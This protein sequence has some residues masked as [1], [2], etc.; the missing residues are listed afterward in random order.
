VGNFDFGPV[1]ILSSSSPSRRRLVA[2]QSLEFYSHRP[3]IM[4]RSISNVI[5]RFL[6]IGCPGRPFATG[7]PRVHDPLPADDAAWD[8]GVSLD[9]QVVFSALTSN[10]GSGTHFGYTTFPGKYPYEQIPVAMPECS[11]AGPSSRPRLQAGRGSESAWWRRNSAG[12]N[13]PSDDR[14]LRKRGSSRLWSNSYGLQVLPHL[15]ISGFGSI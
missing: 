15:L 11:L 6:S 4:Y 1:W 10:T 7:N 2:S 5:V 12:W 8:A 13:T 3:S 14:R 9:W